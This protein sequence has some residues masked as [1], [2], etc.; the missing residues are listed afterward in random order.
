VKVARSVALTACSST[1]SSGQAQTGKKL[2][3]DAA[4]VLLDLAK[5]L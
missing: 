1:Y 5:K 4:Q 2:P 3:V